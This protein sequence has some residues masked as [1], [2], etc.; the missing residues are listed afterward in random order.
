MFS[1]SQ[2]FS[3]DAHAS[4]I[5]VLFVWEVFACALSV[6]LQCCEE[7]IV[8]ADFPTHSLSLSTVYSVWGVPVSLS[9]VGAHGW[10]AR[11]YQPWEKSLSKS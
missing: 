8:Q 11:I 5:Y 9:Y 3:A 7:V 4:E 1:S 6:K 10:V 2:Q